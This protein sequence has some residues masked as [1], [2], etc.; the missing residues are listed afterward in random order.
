MVSC[1][2]ECSEC[3][4][5]PIKINQVWKNPNAISCNLCIFNGYLS[6]S[7]DEDTVLITKTVWHCTSVQHKEKVLSNKVEIARGGIISMTTLTQ[8]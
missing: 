5:I 7:G 1:C 6:T 4:E 3:T 8:N 2:V